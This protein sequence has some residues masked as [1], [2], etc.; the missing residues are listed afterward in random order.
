LS[1]SRLAPSH[2]SL[3]RCCAL[4]CHRFQADQLQV[5]SGS[6]DLIVL[7][8]RR[9]RCIH[10]RD[11]EPMWLRI[12]PGVP[13]APSNRSARPAVMV[14]AALRHGASDPRD[15]QPRAI[16][17]ALDQMWSDLPK[18]WLLNFVAP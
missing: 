3:V 11:D 9:L 6:L 1:F 10:L 12:P 8:D 17:Q 7:Q 16:P 13:H 15:D 5:I 2:P 14:N 18:G 4:F